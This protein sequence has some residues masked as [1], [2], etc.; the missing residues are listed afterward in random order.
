MANAFR[1]DFNVAFPIY[2]DPKLEV[3]RAAGLRR[4]IK[5]TFNAAS[6]KAGVR[7]LRAGHM[8]GMVKGD[9]YQQGGTFVVHPGGKVKFRHISGFAGDIAD[10]GQVMAALT[11][12]AP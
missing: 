9:A 8:Q 7:A 3:Y 6:L 12:K 10:P 11:G 2:V 1:E 4:S 5:T